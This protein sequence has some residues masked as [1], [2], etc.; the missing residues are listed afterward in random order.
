MYRY[1]IELD[2]GAKLVIRHHCMELV[3]TYID[4]RR[5]TQRVKKVNGEE[6][7]PF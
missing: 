1:I 6:Y 3:R 7:I 4:S 5:L 2:S